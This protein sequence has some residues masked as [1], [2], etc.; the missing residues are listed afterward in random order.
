MYLLGEKIK[1]IEKTEYQNHYMY[2]IEIFRVL[3]LIHYDYRRGYGYIMYLWTRCHE[4]AYIFHE[5]S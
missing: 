1:K 2:K 4:I 3:N 5:I